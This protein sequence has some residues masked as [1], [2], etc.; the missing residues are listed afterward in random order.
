VTEVK[1][2]RH[3]WFGFEG[4]GRPWESWVS[5]GYWW[6]SLG[7]CFTRRGAERRARRYSEPWP[8]ERPNVGVSAPLG[9]TRNTTDDPR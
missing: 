1:A 6:R 7:R 4:F 8:N 3:G 2:T 9:E 5:N